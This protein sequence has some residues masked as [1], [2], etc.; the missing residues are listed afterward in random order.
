MTIKEYKIHNYKSFKEGFFKLNRFNLFSGANSAGKSSAIQAL[1][2]AA[3]NIKESKKPHR[4]IARHT[5]SVTFNEVRNFITNAK[6]FDVT[7]STEKQQFRLNFTPCD[8]ALINIEV[9]QSNEVDS[10]LYDLLHDNLFYL[11]ATRTGRLSD[12]TIN[13]NPD[14]NILGLNDEYIVD[15]YYNNRSNV[16][17]TELIKDTS[18]KTLE[19]QVNFWLNKL[20]GYK[21]VVEMD[22]SQYKVKFETKNGKQ[23]YPYHVGTGIS[24]ITGVIIV[25][26][27]MPANSI[28][29]IENPEIHLHPAA[30]AD[31]T[32]FLAMIALS[33]R[34]VLLE[35]HSDH[36]FNGIR[37]LLHKHTLQVDDVS[38]YNFVR[39]QD[40]LSYGTFVTLSQEGGIV[41]YVP[42][43]FEQFDKDLDEI[44]K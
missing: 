13:P 2:N 36:V 44:L 9:M 15:Y 42:D 40:G 28:I 4:F 5:P 35:S 37:R 27:A 33:G 32:D 17:S 11:P 31:L 6:E 29:I 21:L 22:G 12:S 8:D 23:L 30:Q 7:L 14:Q 25:S 38:V 34:Q 19:G 41:N 3:D 24:F 1:L 10:D 26:L 20:T 18:L 43:M 16:L 39:D